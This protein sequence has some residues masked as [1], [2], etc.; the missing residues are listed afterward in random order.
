MIPVAEPTIA[1][2]EIQYVLDALKSGWISSAGK[3]LDLF[4]KKFSAY[5]DVQQG[6]ACSNGTTAL[7]LA[8]ESLGIGKGDEVIIPTFTMIGSANAVVYSGAKP[9]L[10]DSEPNTWNIDV[11]KIEEKLTP[12]TRAIMV[13]HTYGHP[14]DMDKVNEIASRNNLFVIED[15]AEAHGAFYKGR[16]VGSLSDIACFSFYANKIITC[17][18][19]G[20]VVTNNES[21]ANK[22]RKLRNH[23]FGEPR[24]SHQGLGYNY[25]M[26][27]V[28]AAIGLAQ[29]EKIDDYI[30]M[31]RRN[32]QLYNQLLASTKGLITPPEATWARNVYWM[33]GVL[34]QEEFGIGMPQLRSVLLKRG[35]DTRT[36]FI[37][38][39]NQPLYKNGVDERFP[40]CTGDYPHSDMLERKGFYLPSSSHLTKE[41]IGTVVEEI[42]AAREQFV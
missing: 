19:G 27:N 30:N 3:Y 2:N 8:I 26:T 24:F 7:H 1:G 6:I 16:K 14:V 29:L 21:L 36:F 4:E 20:M 10:I 28:Q 42:K 41:Q 22:A 13:V 32:A 33:Y 12:R 18:E 40:D 15:A 35:I 37:G 39:H 38:M 23:Y 31:R 34:V 25:R 11:D 9:V 5:C 17:G